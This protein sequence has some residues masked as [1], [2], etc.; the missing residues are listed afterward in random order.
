MD[1]LEKKICITLRVELWLNFPLEPI[2]RMLSYP[3][4]TVNLLL[5]GQH[6]LQL[7]CSCLQ[8]LWDGGGGWLGGRR[9][10]K[11]GAPPNDWRRSWVGDWAPGRGRKEGSPLG[12]EEVFL[13]RWKGG[14]WGGR[15]EPEF[16]SPYPQDPSSVLTAEAVR[17]IHV[18][19]GAVNAPVLRSFI[20]DCSH[21]II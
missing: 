5:P 7:L 19:L 2:S 4:N 17:A 18:L 14:L 10:R 1:K 3:T 6:R 21:C 8:E 13:D 12:R 9:S 11:Q 15:R 16:L 20:K